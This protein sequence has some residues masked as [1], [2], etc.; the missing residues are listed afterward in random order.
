MDKQTREAI[1]LIAS[2]VKERTRGMLGTEE[3]K[4]TTH[5]EAAEIA[6]KWLRTTNQ[7]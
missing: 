1:E 6:E 7:E 4:G 3:A 5:W 2:F